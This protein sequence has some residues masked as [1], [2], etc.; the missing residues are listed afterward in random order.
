MD[1]L[2]K[3]SRN[4]YFKGDAREIKLSSNSFEIVFSNAVLEHVG[5]NE[6]QKDFINECY[7]VSNKIVF[8]I[9]PYRFFP[10]EMHTKIPLLHFLPKSIFRKILNFLGENFLSE[11]KNLNL[12]SEKDLKKI[13]NKLKITNYKI[14]YSYFLG[15][16]SNIILI[17][18]K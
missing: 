12:L 4:Q 5:S 6:Q 2:K 14:K 7:R 3:I 10:I 17:I 11:E 1:I 13:C 9:T 18:K 8:I 15:F 16:K